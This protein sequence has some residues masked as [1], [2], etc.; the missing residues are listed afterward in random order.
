MTRIA[1]VGTHPNHGYR[2]LTGDDDQDPEVNYVQGHYAPSKSKSYK[3]PRNSQD[4]KKRGGCYI[5]G[6][7]HFWKFCPDK[8]CAICGDKG[9][10][11]RDCKKGRESSKRD[12]IM[13]TKGVSNKGPTSAI[14]P[15]HLSGEPVNALLDSGAVPSVIDKHTVYE[16][17]LEHYMNPKDSKVYGLSHEPVRVVGSLE[18]TV[19][20]GDGHILEH[21]FDVLADTGPTCILGRNLL[22]KFGRIEFNWEERRVRIGDVWK[23]PAWTVEGGELLSRASV[24]TLE[25]EKHCQ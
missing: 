2:E 20:L 6:K 3:P 8:R 1:A 9:H 25:E 23:I 21:S 17:D 18:L 13:V 5:C 16:L 14:L 15:I 10:P 12:Q 24:A 19:D 4:S 7:E 22:E 11:M